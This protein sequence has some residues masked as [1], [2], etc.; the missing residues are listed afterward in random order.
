MLSCVYDVM[1]I[2]VNSKLCFYSLIHG[3]LCNT[4]EKSRGKN[5]IIVLP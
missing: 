4:L 2:S 3:I 5:L 1:Q